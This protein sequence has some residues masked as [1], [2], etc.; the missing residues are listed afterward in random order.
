MATINSVLQYDG[1]MP[2]WNGYNLS[3]CHRYVPTSH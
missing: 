2:V 3:D 1:N